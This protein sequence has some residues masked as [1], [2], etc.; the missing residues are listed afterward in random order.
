ML[1]HMHSH[2][3]GWS[4]SCYVLKQFVTIVISWHISILF[5]KFMTIIANVT[6]VMLNYTKAYMDKIIIFIVINNE[7][8]C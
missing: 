7:I 6:I 3:S 2:E 1:T 8:P 5:I 4:L